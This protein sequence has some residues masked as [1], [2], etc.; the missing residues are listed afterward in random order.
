MSRGNLWLVSWVCVLFAQFAQIEQF[1]TTATAATLKPSWV[2]ETN[3]H[4]L[5]PRDAPSVGLINYISQ[6]VCSL[7]TPLIYYY[8]E[9]D[10]VNRLE[11]SILRS[12]H[13]CAV[14]PIRA[15]T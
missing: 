4:Q 7:D 2:Q 6:V 13:Q 3:N 10:K 12:I 11:D 14:A 9:L 5:L 8:Y 15:G 1:A